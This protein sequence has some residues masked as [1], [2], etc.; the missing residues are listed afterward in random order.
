MNGR[1]ARKAML[2]QLRN[3]ILRK[4]RKVIR[5]EAKRQLQCYLREMSFWS[6]LKWLFGKGEIPV[7]PFTSESQ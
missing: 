1:R 4:N 5:R 7:Q 3:N 2:N 6:R